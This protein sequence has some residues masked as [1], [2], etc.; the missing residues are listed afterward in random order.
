MKAELS[1]KEK[2]ILTLIPENVTEDFALKVFYD[3]YFVE[4]IGDQGKNCNAK[5]EFKSFKEESK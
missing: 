2:P 4:D 5:Y 1:Y 3:K